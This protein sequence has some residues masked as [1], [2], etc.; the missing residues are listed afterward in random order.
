[1]PDD[2]GLEWIQSV[3]DPS[4]DFNTPLKGP[5]TPIFG[6]KSDISRA[7][8]GNLQDGPFNTICNSS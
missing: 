2:K 7:A 6:G 1:V 3:C 8:L 4:N 5:F